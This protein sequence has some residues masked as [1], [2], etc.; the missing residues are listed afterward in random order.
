M[1]PGDTP[2]CEVRIDTVKPS[3][4]AKRGVLATG[5][6]VLNQDNVAVLEYATRVM[7]K[8]RG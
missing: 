2:R 1:R 3:S 4:D 5:V 6:K 7:L 8:S